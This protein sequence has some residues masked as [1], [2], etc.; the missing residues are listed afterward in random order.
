M[1][2]YAS[3]TRTRRT[4]RTRPLFHSGFS[5]FGEFCT[6]PTCTH[7]VTRRAP[8]NSLKLLTGCVGCVGCVHLIAEY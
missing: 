6:H 8:I 1:I 3:Y 2:Y 7:P 4:A 5:V